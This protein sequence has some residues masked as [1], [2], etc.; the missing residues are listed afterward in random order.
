M[1]RFIGHNYMT[2]RLIASVKCFREPI[3][4]CQNDCLLD[5]GAAASGH[6]LVEMAHDAMSIYN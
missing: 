3:R 1:K 4:F 2:V 5:V 6:S